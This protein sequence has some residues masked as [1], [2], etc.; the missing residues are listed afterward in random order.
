M[1]DPEPTIENN[2]TSSLE[3]SYQYEV[4]FCQQMMDANN[5]TC[6]DPYFAIGSYFNGTQYYFDEDRAAQPPTDCTPYTGD[7]YKNIEAT[8]ISQD[9]DGE[10]QT[11]VAITY[12]GGPA[13]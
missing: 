1:T 5:A 9:V 12:T 10:T 11:G 4:G 13:C 6:N 2:F 8:T 7:T 3:W